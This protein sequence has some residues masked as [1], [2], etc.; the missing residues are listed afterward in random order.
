MILCIKTYINKININ[1]VNHKILWFQ[2]FLFKQANISQIC[3]SFVSIPIACNL[4]TVDKKRGLLFI[5]N[6]DKLT[7]LLSGSEINVERKI[8]VN[9]PFIISKIT[10]NC[11]YSYLA[12]TPLVPKVFIYDAQAFVKHVC[13]L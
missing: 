13:I 2:E 6:N 11:D 8:E 7:I 9:L 5:A 4:V 1:N 10:F 3:N 12:V